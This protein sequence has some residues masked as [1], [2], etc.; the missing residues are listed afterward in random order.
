MIWIP[1]QP[2]GAHFQSVLARITIHHC[3]MALKNN[4]TPSIGELG[5]Q[6]P[7][8][9]RCDCVDQGIALAPQLRATAN[10]LRIGGQ[11]RCIGLA[12]DQSR[13]DDHRPGRCRRDR[14]R[15]RCAPAFHLGGVDV[16]HRADAAGHTRSPAGTHFYSGAALLIL[17]T[18]ISGPPRRWSCPC[19][20]TGLASPFLEEAAWCHR[21]QAPPW[22][23][24]TKSPGRVLVFPRQ[25]NEHAP[26]SA[27]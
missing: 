22:P 13:P 12:P 2:F 6:P 7:G 23:S 14:T 15:P 10:F 1:P 18:A 21:H 19:S 26:A 24:A 5:V 16:S 20:D 9:A 4:Q 27:C 17:A 8:S 3:R 11:P 25:Q